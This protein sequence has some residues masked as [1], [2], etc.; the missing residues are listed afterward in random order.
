MDIS[1]K[2]NFDE[3]KYDNYRIR[4]VNSFDFEESKDDNT[5]WDSLPFQYDEDDSEQIDT[6]SLFPPQL[7]SLEDIERELDAQD[8]DETSNDDD[9]DGD[10]DYY[11]NH[12]D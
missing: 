4:G 1:A 2:Y 12:Y 7:T 10:G 11:S 9:D 5:T 8:T 6:K 3:S